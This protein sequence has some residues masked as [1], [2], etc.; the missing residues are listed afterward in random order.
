MTFE[1]FKKVLLDRSSD[2]SAKMYHYGYTCGEQNLIS[3]EYIKIA[4]INYNFSE[5]EQRIYIRKIIRGFNDSNG[6]S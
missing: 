6:R 5:E 4:F 1:E 3:F 2:M